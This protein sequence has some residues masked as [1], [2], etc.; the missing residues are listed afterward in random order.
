MKADAMVNAE[1]RLKDEIAKHPFA[2][3]MQHTKWAEMKNKFSDAGLVA[4]LDAVEN[5][6][7]TACNKLS[8]EIQRMTKTHAL[9]Q[10]IDND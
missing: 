9:N 3:S 8:K 10:Q 2:Q 5:V 7:G 1:Q 6:L 4:N